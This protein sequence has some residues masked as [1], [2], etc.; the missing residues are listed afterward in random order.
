M[1]ERPNKGGGIISEILSWLTRYRWVAVWTLS[2]SSPH[3]SPLLALSTGKRIINCASCLALW[4]ER[5]GEAL[6]ALLLAEPH[7][8]TRIFHIHSLISA[9]DDFDADGFEQF[10]KRW[11]QSDVRPYRSGG[12]YCSYIAHKLLRDDTEWELYGEIPLK[13]VKDAQ[14]N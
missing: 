8:G 2:P 14:C 13:E 10:S 4:K 7:P 6:G 12:G 5:T 3:L 9:A 1:N 11:G